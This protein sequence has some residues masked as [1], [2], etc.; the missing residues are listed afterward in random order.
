MLANEVLCLADIFLYCDEIC[1]LCH[2]LTARVQYVSGMNSLFI[3]SY[4]PACGYYR[5]YTH[6]L[7]ELQLANLNTK[8]NIVAIKKWHPI[9]WFTVCGKDKVILFPM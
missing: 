2:A 4:L 9:F 3:H 8:R 5:F 6:P 1:G 7:T